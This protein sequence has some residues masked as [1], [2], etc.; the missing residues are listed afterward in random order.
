MKNIKSKSR[1]RTPWSDVPDATELQAFIDDCNQNNYYKRHPQ[2]ADAG[3]TTLLNS[4]DMRE[5]RH[6]QSSDM[7]KFGYTSNRI[8]R[9]RCKDCGRTFTVLTNTIFDNHKIPISEWLDFLLSIF[10]YGS[11]NLVSKS[12]RNAYNTTKFWIEKVSIVLHEYQNDLVLSEDLELDETYYKVRHNDIEYKQDGKQYR[13]LCRNQICIG[14][15]CDKTNVICFV[16]GKGK[17]TK[18]GTLDAFG[19]HIENGATIKHD[20]EQAHDLLVET[21]DLK[22]I[23]FDSREIKK[24]PDS[25]NPLNGSFGF[26][27]DK[28][29]IYH[30]RRGLKSCKG[31]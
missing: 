29:L 18:Q 30:N 8:R 6:C 14:I 5:C 7:Q 28:G 1:R 4:F 23:E 25:G 17:P 3:E 31:G 10:R 24:L 2:L 16:E 21:L 27:M 15:A 9:F 26:S 11:F 22:S 19:S 12:N 13:G 20:I